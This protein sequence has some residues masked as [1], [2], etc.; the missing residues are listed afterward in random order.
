MGGCEGTEHPRA[1]RARARP[2]AYTYTNL[3]FYIYV[4]E[5]CWYMGTG[6]EP[7]NFGRWIMEVCP[8]V[9]SRRSSRAYI[10]TYTYNHSILCARRLNLYIY[11]YTEALGRSFLVLVIPVAYMC[12]LIDGIATWYFLSL[13]RL[14]LIIRHPWVH[15]FSKYYRY[16]ASLRKF[17]IIIKT[18]FF[19]TASFMYGHTN[20]VCDE[21]D[22]YIWKK[23]AQA[24]FDFCIFEFSIALMCISYNCWQTAFLLSYLARLIF[25]CLNASW[26]RI[27]LI[28]RWGNFVFRNHLLYA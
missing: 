3:C 1:V 8:A 6:G 4:G 16:F 15:L 21:T 2:F 7:P 9:A 5:P 26:R 25:D 19:F 24:S 22:C 28:L 11:I 14:P 12:A 17:I 27:G 18:I 13:P 20:Y 10:H 23:L